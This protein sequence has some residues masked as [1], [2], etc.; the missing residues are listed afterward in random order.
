MV[1]IDWTTLKNAILAEFAESHHDEKYEK[2]L[3]GLSLGDR[4]PSALLAQMRT[5]APS[6]PEDFIRKK[7]L[8]CMPEFLR[9]QLLIHDIGDTT[10]LA[11][12][13]DKLR[14]SFQH[15]GI[16]PHGQ[17]SAFDSKPQSSD[18]NNRSR[19]KSRGINRDAS[20]SPQKHSSEMGELIKLIKQLV[21]SSSRGRSKS[22]SNSKPRSSTH[23][24]SDKREEKDDT[25]AGKC[26]YHQ[27]FGARARK[28]RPPCSS[29]PEAGEG[30]SHQPK[31]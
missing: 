27:N 16:I 7:W 17:I 25:S 20:V 31:N 22:P 10:T 30:D 12:I 6:M 19:S 11:T 14:E 24:F 29:N 21:S 3:H 9:G 18:G 1:H 4:K 5:L 15:Y 13:A 23:T 28:C 26:Y 2:I 8:E